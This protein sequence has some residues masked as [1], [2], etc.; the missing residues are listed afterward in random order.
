MAHTAFLLVKGDFQ[1]IYS[2]IKEHHLHGSR[3]FKTDFDCRL[4]L[5]YLEDVKHVKELLKMVPK[6]LEIINA[7]LQMRH[8]SSN[9]SN[10]NTTYLERMRAFLQKQKTTY[11]KRWFRFSEQYFNDFLMESV[12]WS[13]STVVYRRLDFLNQQH[14]NL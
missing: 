3:M 12:D 13:E 9:H 2:G 7:R 11:V 14:F 4:H 8:P 10:R 6:Q 5:Q 1:Q